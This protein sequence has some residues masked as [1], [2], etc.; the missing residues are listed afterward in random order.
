MSGENFLRN[1]W[2]DFL[3]DPIRLNCE[4]MGS[5]GGLLAIL[6]GIVEKSNGK[7]TPRRH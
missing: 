4:I 2:P 3:W 7:N 6:R 1:L 5:M